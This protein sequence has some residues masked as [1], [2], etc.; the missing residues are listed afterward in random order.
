MSSAESFA[1]VFQN[2]VS[3]HAQYIDQHAYL[4]THVHTYMHTC[5]VHVR[6]C[7]H[8]YTYMYMP[9]LHW[10]AYVC[11][12][13]YRKVQNLTLLLQDCSL[14]YN[15]CTHTHTYKHT[16]ACTHANT[17]TH[18]HMHTCTHTCTHTHTHTVFPPVQ[19]LTHHPNHKPLHVH[20]VH[21]QNISCCSDSH[22]Y[23]MVKGFAIPSL[24]K[25]H[26]LYNTKSYNLILLFP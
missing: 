22:I 6:S 17:H 21:I 16:C 15:T 9:I 4:Y 13:H 26:Y 14:R 5:T 7:S 10:F 8:V 1:K 11:S 20:S 25:L 2:N 18:T 23:I 12:P 24:N 19:L 3:L